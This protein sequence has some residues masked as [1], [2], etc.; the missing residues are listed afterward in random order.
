[1]GQSVGES[2]FQ[3]TTMRRTDFVRERNPMHVKNKI[4]GVLGALVLTLGMTTGI[5][6]AQTDVPVSLQVLCSDLSNIKITGDGTFTPIDLATNAPSYSSSTGTNALT[7]EVNVGCDF[8]PWHVN[9]TVDR[10]DTGLGLLGPW[11]SGDHF[12]LTAGPV[13]S[14]FGNTLLTTP[15]T[16][17]NATFDPIPGFPIG[18]AGSTAPIFK[19]SNVIICFFGCWDT[20]LD[21]PAPFVSTAQFTGHLTGLEDLPLVEATYSSTLTVELVNEAG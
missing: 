17:S 9:A 20:G 12:S 11:F 10:F 8:G 19:T 2:T 4:F 16:A 3:A 1:M 7:V 15:P 21:Y 5:A 18:D 14:Y 13:T 6:S